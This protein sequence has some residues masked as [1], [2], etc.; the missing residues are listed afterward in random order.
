MKLLLA[1][2][3]IALSRAIT[4]ILEKNNYTVDAV[5]NGADALSYLEEGIT[6]L[7]FWIS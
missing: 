6:T 4:A 3:E 1:E 2:D 7:P 5:C